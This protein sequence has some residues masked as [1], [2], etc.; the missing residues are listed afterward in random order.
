MVLAVETVTR[1]ED[2]YPSVLEVVFPLLGFA[3]IVASVIL[4]AY[5]IRRGR[6]GPPVDH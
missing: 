5:L 1:A 2:L 3:V 6:S 4:V